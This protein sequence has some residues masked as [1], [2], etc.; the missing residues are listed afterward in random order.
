MTSN[1]KLIISIGTCIALL[2]PFG[3]QAT[4]IT[5]IAISGTGSYTIYELPNPPVVGPQILELVTPPTLAAVNDIL[6]DNT[7]V[8]N[9]QLGKPSEPSLEKFLTVTFAGGTQAIFSN[10][11]KTDWTD[12]GDALIKSYITAAAQSVGKTLDSTQMGNAVTKFL[13][14][15]ELASDPSIAKIDLVNGRIV[16]GQ[17]GLLNPADYLTNLLGVTAPPNSQASEAVKVTYAG[18]TQYLYSFSASRTGYS[19]ADTVS[20]T[21]RYIAQTPEPTTLLLLSVGFMGLGYMRRHNKRN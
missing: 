10:L 13:T 11:L 12:N 8:G 7:R 17:D 14:V 15:W 16:V 6:K 1:T 20:Y 4:A 9:V 21:G 18:S 3:A 2:M 19:T 5:N